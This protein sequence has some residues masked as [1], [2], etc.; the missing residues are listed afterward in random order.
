MKARIPAAVA[1]LAAELAKA[2]FQAYLVGGCVRDLLLKREPKDWDIATDATPEKIQGLFPES[3]YENQFGTVGVKTGS[4]EPQLKIVEITTFRTE[5]GYSDRRH[6]DQVK[7]ARTVA[8]DLA[9]RDFTM[10]AIAM[11]V[12]GGIVDPY[13][14]AADIKAGV[15]RT[16]GGPE[17]RFGED[18]LRLMRAVRLATEL[19]ELGFE[20]EAGTKKAV[21]KLAPLLKDIALERVRDELVKILLAPRA[22][23][24]ILLLEEAG[25][26]Q[27]I[28]PEL[29]EGIGVGQ[30]LHHIYTVF[31]HSVRALRYTAEKGYALPVRLAAF[32]HD[33]GK[34]R[35]KAGEGLHSTFYGHEVVGARMAAKALEHLRFP[36]DLIEQ[37]VH[38]IRRHMFYYN[39]GDVSPAGVRR[40]VARVGAENIDDLLKVREAD[41]IGSGTP[42]AVPYKLRHLLFM[43][44][45]VKRDPI[46]PKMLKVNGEDV[47][48]LTGE[49]PSPKIGQILGALLEEVLDDPDKNKKA[50]LEKRVVELNKLPAKKL[51]ELLRQARERKDELEGEAEEEMKKKFRVQ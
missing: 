1:E 51:E 18:A 34:P 37:A 26:L 39:V 15:I 8:E 21:H 19:G 35:T 32:L 47:M 14:G 20:I 5:A 16:V 40:F 33:L 22:A 42:K 48:R 9:R 2:G 10:N 6:P 49:R 50:Y 4:E 11:D 17:E 31:E 46:S 43:I 25:L 41:R 30:N 7:F 28:L 36:K 3:V 45:N 27:Y 44:E 12:D 13:G 24:G 29:R 23:D 38:L